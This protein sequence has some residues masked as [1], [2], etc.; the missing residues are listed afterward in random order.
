[1]H[2]C[3]GAA[4]EHD[5]GIAAPDRLRALA[6]GVR[7]RGTRRDRRVVRAAQPQID[8]DLTGRRV[9]EYVREEPRRHPVVASFAAHAVLLEDPD[10]AA[11]RGSDQDPGPRRI[12]ALD[13]GIRPRLPRRRDRE[14]DVPL[15]P[16][17]VLGADDRLGL[18]PLDLRG[19]SNGE[20]ARVEGADPVDA[21]R[22][23]DGSVPRRP[24]IEP[25]RRDCS[26][27]GDDD[28]AHGRRA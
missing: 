6:H 10:D 11:D 12:D 18:E 13:A 20:V 9:D 25:E 4:R 2:T 5:I 24:G 23:G 27:T 8:R 7:T 22:P 16:A 14:H 21:A 3:L 26:E 17:R 28:A 1:M 19:D 15:E